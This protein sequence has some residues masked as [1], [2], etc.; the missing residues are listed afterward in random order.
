MTNFIVLPD[1]DSDYYFP[2]TA[3]FL[4]QLNVM[5]FL[6]HVV[7]FLTYVTLLTAATPTA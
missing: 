5:L 6:K 2:Y 3:S 7:Y 1:L 4:K